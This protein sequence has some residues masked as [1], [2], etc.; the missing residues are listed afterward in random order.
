MGRIVREGVGPRY[1]PPALARPPGERHGWARGGPPRPGVRRGATL[2]GTRHRG[3]RPPDPTRLSGGTPGTPPGTHK[4]RRTM[5]RYG[6]ELTLPRLP[7]PISL[8]P[9]RPPGCCCVPRL[10]RPFTSATRPDRW[11]AARLTPSSHSRRASPRRRIAG[12]SEKRRCWPPPV[13]GPPP[14]TPARMQAEAWGAGG[15]RGPGGGRGEP[16]RLVGRAAN[17]YMR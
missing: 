5:K 9:A 1:G 13:C 4:P 17:G 2:G 14:A 7:D 11:V 6:H 10:L 12:R 3:P 8:H 15:G 16:E